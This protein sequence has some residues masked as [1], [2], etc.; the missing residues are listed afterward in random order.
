MSA[1]G[2]LSLFLVRTEG[3]DGFGSIS[4][5]DIDLV[6]FIEGGIAHVLG[7]HALPE[8]LIAAADLLQFSR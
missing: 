3:A 7:S 6:W 1:Q 5:D 2:R 8:T 4:F